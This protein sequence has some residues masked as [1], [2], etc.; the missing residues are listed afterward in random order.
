MVNEKGRAYMPTVMGIAI[1]EA[2]KAASLK[3]TVPC[4]EAMGVATVDLGELAFNM[5]K[6]LKLPLMEVSDMM[7]S[8]LM[9]NQASSQAVSQPMRRRRVPPN[10]RRRILLAQRPLVDECLRNQEERYYRLAIKY[11]LM[12]INNYLVR[13]F[14]VSMLAVTNYRKLPV[15]Q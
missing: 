12:I 11:E 3:D 8:G 10:V 15:V 6:E 14:S 7:A 9:V 4:Q 13:V 5:G 1:L 2:G